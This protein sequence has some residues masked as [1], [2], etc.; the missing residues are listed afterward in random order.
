MPKLIF[1][2]TMIRRAPSLS[3]RQFHYDTL[4]GIDPSPSVFQCHVRNLG[5][6][7]RRQKNGSHDT[8]LDSSEEGA[9]TVSKRGRAFSFIAFFSFIL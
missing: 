4:P 1:S 9:S 6:K 3:A 7:I 2:A 8:P 5:D